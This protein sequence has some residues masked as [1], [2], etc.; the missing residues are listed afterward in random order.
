MK[1]AY[2][3]LLL[4]IT[5]IALDYGQKPKVP[6]NNSPTGVWIYQDNDKKVLKVTYASEFRSDLSVKI[7]NESGRVLYSEKLLDEKFRHDRSYDISGYPKGFYTVEV[8]TER[9][10]DVER[11][12]F[13]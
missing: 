11:V 9:A 13:N 3:S 10:Q 5:G 8:D 6:D 2:I 1:K 7:K 4:M 12:E